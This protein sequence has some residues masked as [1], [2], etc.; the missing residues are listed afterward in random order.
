MNLVAL[1]KSAEQ[2][3]TTAAMNLMD[4]CDTEGE[5]QVGL[6]VLIRQI[7]QHLLCNLVSDAQISNHI[8]GRPPFARCEMEDLFGPLEQ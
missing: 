3:G 1:R 7:Q 5:R 2:I 4:L 8:E 6:L